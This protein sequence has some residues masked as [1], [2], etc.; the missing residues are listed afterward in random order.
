MSREMIEM[1]GLDIA[2]CQKSKSRE[3]YGILEI[4]NQVKTKDEQCSSS[5]KLKT[6]T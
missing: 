4:V 5:P 3:T 1:D 2:K 6:K